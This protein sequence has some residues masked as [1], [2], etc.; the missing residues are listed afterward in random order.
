[1]KSGGPGRR[2]SGLGSE[3]PLFETAG[4]VTSANAPR[5]LSSSSS[6]KKMQPRVFVKN[7][8]AGTLKWCGPF[9]L[10]PLGGVWL[11]IELDLMNPKL[12]D[13]KLGG[14]R[15]FGPTASPNRAVFIQASTKQVF[16]LK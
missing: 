3:V 11:G 15:V 4:F 1:M 5:L 8:G 9:Y 10:R 13:G 12:G 7:Y 6:K 14:R 16:L 2:P